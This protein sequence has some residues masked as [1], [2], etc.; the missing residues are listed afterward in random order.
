[1]AIKTQSNGKITTTMIGFLFCS[2]M[3]TWYSDKM[4]NNNHRDIKS[5]S[6]VECDMLETQELNGIYHTNWEY[7]YNNQTYTYADE[8]SITPESHDCCLLVEQP[9]KIVDCVS[10]SNTKFYLFTIC[11]WAVTVMYICCAYYI[12][13][14]SE[15]KILAI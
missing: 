5:Q 9:F 10:S 8:S 3:T 11:M 2:V 13:P 14:R 7:V 4:I 1:M 12:L 6:R 15:K